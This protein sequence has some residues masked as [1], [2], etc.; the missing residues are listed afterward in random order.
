MIVMYLMPCNL[1][2]FSL[3]VAMMYFGCRIALLRVWEGS[4]HMR[5]FPGLVI[6]GSRSRTTMFETQSVGWETLTSWPVA[7]QLSSALLIFSYFDVG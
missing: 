2:R 3:K 7:L 4:K 1:C 5:I 6:V